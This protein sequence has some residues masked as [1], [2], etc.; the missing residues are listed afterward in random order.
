MRIDYFIPAIGQQEMLQDCIDELRK[1]QQ[2]G[3]TEIHVIDNGS[4]PPLEI[5][6]AKV[7]RFEDNLG[8]IESLVAAKRLSNAEILGFAHSDFFIHE[9]GWDSRLVQAFS[10]DPKLGL[11]GAV[12]ARIAALNGGRAEVYCSFTRDG[13]VHGYQTPPGVH[14]AVL[15]DGCMMVFR[16]TVLDALNIPD[17]R[18]RTH[19]FYDRDWSLQT[20]VG[21]WKVGAICLDC[22]HLGGQ[23][24]CR[25]D[26]QKW[27]NERGGEQKMYEENEALYLNKWKHVL[28]VSVDS[29]WTVKTNA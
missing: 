11:V 20:A 26:F 22:D 2:H 9:F 27:I 4:N 23:T 17:T 15:L 14:P 28:P 24:A 12:G 8:M 5:R 25:D 16:R 18:F 10:S 3:D 21:G 13:E 29:K 1:N 19:H 7:H 6:D